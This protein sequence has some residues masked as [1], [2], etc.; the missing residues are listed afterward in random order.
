M[1]ELTKEQLQSLENPEVLPPR[2]VDPRTQQRFVLLK[3]EEYERLTAEEYDAGPW[4]DEET[5]LLAAEA[6][7]LLDN[8]GKDAWEKNT[9]RCSSALIQS[10]VAIS[11]D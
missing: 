3:I 1:I 11:E 7:E 9:N 5:A 6:G 8:F 10:L 4:T 2:V